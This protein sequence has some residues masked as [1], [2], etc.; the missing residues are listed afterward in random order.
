MQLSD[1]QALLQDHERLRSAR[2][3]FFRRERESLGE[4][5]IQE[6]YAFEYRLY[7]DMEFFREQ[8]PTREAR[9][10]HIEQVELLEA[11]RVADRQRFMND[12]AVRKALYLSPEQ[13]RSEQK[14]GDRT[15]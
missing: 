11:K 2:R 12:S 9:I 1:D 3:R 4:Q 14:G 6:Q 10:E 15:R 13:R 7:N 5:G 8:F